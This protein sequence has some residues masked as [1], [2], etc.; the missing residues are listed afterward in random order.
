MPGKL[1]SEA[2][3]AGVERSPERDAVSAFVI[4]FNEEEHIRDCLSSLSFCDEVIVIDSF[5]KDDTVKIAEEM[6]AKVIQRE[7]PGYRAQKAFGLEQCNCKWVLNLDAD[8]RVDSTLAGEIQTILEGRDKNI[9]GDPVVGYELNR[10]VFHLGRWWRSGGWYPEYRL[11]FFL[12]E[13]VEWGGRDPHEKPVTGGRVERLRG[14]LHHF[15][16]TNLA[17]QFKRLLNFA[18]V[19]AAESFRIGKRSQ[20][21]DILCR[22]F[23]RSFKFYF[24]KR[25]YKEGTAGIVVAIAEGVYTF[26]KYALLWE[27]N[28][29]RPKDD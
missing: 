5:S 7:W 28:R 8:E 13:S 4:T 3:K 22:P 23:L 9:S 11:R 1:T 29:N 10:V 26:M 25:G 24:L 18:E 15:S 12:K 19:S 2:L 14:E 6:G 20:V 16:Y 17:D 21:H 27:M